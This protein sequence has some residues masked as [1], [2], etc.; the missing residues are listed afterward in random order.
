MKRKKSPLTV[1]KGLIINWKDRSKD[2]D[3]ADIFDH[4]TSHK[5]PIYR[6]MAQE[7]FDRV[8]SLIVKKR[9]LFWHIEVDVVFVYPDGTEQRSSGEFESWCTFSEVA[10]HCVQIHQEGLREGNE[11]HYKYTE[12]TATC[13]RVE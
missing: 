2:L 3:K 4:N 8:H 5:N 6:L 12:F 7:I 9:R 10:P 1:V 13:L 11:E